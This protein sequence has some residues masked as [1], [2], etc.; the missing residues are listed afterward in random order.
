MCIHRFYAAPNEAVQPGHLS[1]YQK[2]S[3][4]ASKGA[5]KCEVESHKMLVSNFKMQ[6]LDDGIKSISDNP[7][8]E[9]KH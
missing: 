9:F 3:S 5:T 8:V 7:S 6:G 2:G 4:P 1:S